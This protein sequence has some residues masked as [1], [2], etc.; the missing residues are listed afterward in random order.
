MKSRLVEAE[1]R[2]K[3]TVAIK[4]WAACPTML[5]CQTVARKP[6]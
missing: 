6:R 5:V 2:A 1:P 4:R 3:A